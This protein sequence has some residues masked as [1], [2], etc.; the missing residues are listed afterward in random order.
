M[1]S[2]LSGYLLAILAAL[3]W[4]ISGTFAQFLIQNRTIDPGWLVT[5][6]LLVS[7]ILLLAIPAFKKPKSI[8]APWKNKTDSI[9]ILIFGVLGMLAVQY[10]FF[11][12]IKHSNA[13]TAT[14]LQYLGPVFIAC[15]F[16]IKEKR[17]PVAQE[18]VAIF[19]AL[20]G[21]FLIV[22][23][24]SLDSLSISIPALIWGLASAIALATYS[25]TPEGLLKRHD[26]TVVIGWG[27][28]IGGVAL[29][30]IN[31]PFAVSGNWDLI[32][33][34]L[35]AFVILPGS[36]VAFYSYLTAV[37]IIGPTK[38]SLLAC[39]EPLSAALIA[40]FWLHTPFGL[41]DWAGM[42]FILLTIALLTKKA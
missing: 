39:A 10:T 6:R 8:F 37:K 38:S 42:I 35:A 2:Y 23:H 25:I 3:L 26:T 32:T 1:T 27:M 14:I 22:T 20:L 31:N 11:V 4:G 29:S 15:Y 24:G 36:L 40:V 7:G 28:L 41:Y 16:S 30:F 18:I 21:T 9:E 34:L 5:V 13:A 33:F 19:F 12:T 17:L